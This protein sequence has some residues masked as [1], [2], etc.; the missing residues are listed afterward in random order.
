MELSSVKLVAVLI[1]GNLIW[2]HRERLHLEV[3]MF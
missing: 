2:I 3:S 1:V